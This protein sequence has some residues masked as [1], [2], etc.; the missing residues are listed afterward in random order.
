MFTKEEV[1]V[2]TDG[3]I[4]RDQL[5]AETASFAHFMEHRNYCDEDG[6]TGRFA[7]E[8]FFY[9]LKRKPEMLQWMLDQLAK[10]KEPVCFTEHEND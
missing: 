2:A 9:N 1:F 5:A 8:S 6:D 10:D 4:H 3:S 7:V